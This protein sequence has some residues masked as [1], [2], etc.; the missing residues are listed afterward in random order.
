VV[1]NRCA[2]TARAEE[3]IDDLHKVSAF[4]FFF[5]PFFFFFFF[6][7]SQILFWV[8]CTSVLHKLHSVTVLAPS[9]IV[10]FTPNLSSLESPL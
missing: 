3:I 10:T 4:S 1:Q 5:P 8:S 2:R 9:Q 7:P 6:Q